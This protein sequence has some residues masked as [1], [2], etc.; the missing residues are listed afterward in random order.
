MPRCSIRHL[1]CSPMR[2]AKALGYKGDVILPVSVA[3]EKAGKPVRLRMK[4]DYAV[5]EKLCVPAEGR[6][7][8]S[9]GW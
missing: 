7:E 2:P 9:L 4:I 3:P 8:L 6:A 1:I 5:C